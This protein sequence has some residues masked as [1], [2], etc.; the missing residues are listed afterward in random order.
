VAGD[1]QGEFLD[2]GEGAADVAGGVEPGL[3]A[4]GLVGGEVD[5]DGLAVALAGPLPVGAVR[6]GRVGVAPAS[7]L[8]AA[9]AAFDEGA[10]QG[11]PE[12]IILRE[13]PSLGQTLIEKFEQ[14]ATSASYAIVVLTADDEG[15]R[16]SQGTHN[17]RGRQNVIFE[18]GYFFGILGRSRVS[19]LLHPGV[20]KP[21]DID[22]IAYIN[23]DDN[24]AWKTELFRELEHASI[25]IDISAAI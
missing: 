14:H 25:H 2:A 13:K 20:E 11:E 1:A 10:G 19:V 24:G 12:T 16:A 9:G 8:A 4:G 3:V 7:R 15:G 23:F 6:A 21:S 5:G 17:P 22:G 18:M